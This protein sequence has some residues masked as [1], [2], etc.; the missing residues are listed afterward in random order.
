[1]V[2]SVT[3]DTVTP[4]HASNYNRKEGEKEEWSMVN[5]GQ[6]H[7]KISTKSEIRNPKQ[8]QMTKNQMTKTKTAASGGQ[9]VLF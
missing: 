2:A 9:L 7:S 6:R 8:I 4:L 5:S 1:M 3:R